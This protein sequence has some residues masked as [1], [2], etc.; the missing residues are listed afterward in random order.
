MILTDKLEADITQLS[1]ILYNLSEKE[2][3]DEKSIEKSSLGG[4]SE[5]DLSKKSNEEPLK[6]NRD[7]GGEEK[8]LKESFLR[9]TKLIEQLHKTYKDD[10]IIQTIILAKE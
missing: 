9:P 6:Q 4:A 10:N 2:S 8:S 1:A 3:T 5:E 7:Q